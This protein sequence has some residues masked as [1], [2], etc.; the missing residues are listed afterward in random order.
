MD[1]RIGY[2]PERAAEALGVGRSTMFELLASGEIES[3]KVG[4]ARIVPAEALHAY[5]RRLRAEQAGQVP[6]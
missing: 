1:E 4:R 6:A 2:R 5:M 3:V